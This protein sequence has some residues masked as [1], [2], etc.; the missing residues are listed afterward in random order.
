MK[1]HLIFDL[2]GTL[3]DS[4]ASILQCFA[5]AFSSTDTALVMPLTP[6]VIGPPLMETLKRLSGRQDDALLKTLA[7]AFKHHYDNTGYLQSVVFEGIPAMLQQLNDQGYACYIATNKRFLPTEKII[8]HLGWQSLFKGVYAL[9][10]FKPAVSSKAEMIARVVKDHALPVAE[11]VYIGDRLEDGQSADAN[12]M[13]FTLVSWGY[14]GDVG[15]REPHWHVCA[16]VDALPAL[17]AT[18]AQKGAR[19]D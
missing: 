8:A 5:L 10:F 14:A 4:A 2:D 11:C 15:L 17:I 18:L 19:D 6:D 9:D 7:D 1:Q 3:I 16:D 12:H 13:T